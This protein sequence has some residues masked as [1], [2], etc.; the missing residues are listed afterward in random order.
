M[1]PRAAPADQSEGKAGKHD[2]GD[3]YKKEPQK[4]ATR[5]GVGAPPGRSSPPPQ[6]VLFMLR[7]AGGVPAASMESRAAKAEASQPAEPPP[8]QS[9][10]AKQ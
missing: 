5:D 4:E 3:A 6:R 9:A 2:A 7:L 10:P 8:A 1:L